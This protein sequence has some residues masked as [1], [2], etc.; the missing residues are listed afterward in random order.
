MERVGTL[1]GH[2][3]PVEKVCQKASEPQW[4]ESVLEKIVPMV[5]MFSVVFVCLLT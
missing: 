3:R 2:E 4:T 1:P 5:A